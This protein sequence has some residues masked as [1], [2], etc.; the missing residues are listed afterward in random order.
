MTTLPQAVRRSD[1]L[2]KYV[3]LVFLI[4]LLGVMFFP[5]LIVL[6]N[7]F[8]TPAEYAGGGPL[9]LPRGL[10][11]AGITEFWS[12]V[13]F[14]NKLLNSALISLAVAVA[15]VLLSLLNAFALGIGKVRGR[16]GLLVFFLIANTLPQE[17]LA[18][19]LYYFAKALKIYDTQLAVIIVFSVIQSAFG[20]YLLSSVFSTFPKELIEAA[21]IDGCNK[22]QLLLWVVLPASVPTLAVLFT[23]FFIWTWNEFFLP[24]ILLIS[25]ARQTVPLAIAVLQGQH[26]MDATTSSASAL[27]G[28]LPCILFFL[29]FQRTLTRGV[30]AG[31]IK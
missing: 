17:S 22:L 2:G 20:T 31:S 5:F 7:A 21:Q 16:L 14:T 12:R 19:P 6:I 10:S 26:N 27:L 4:A 15:G 28:I 23:F 11:L 9:S 24:L 8:K 3:V 18:Y 1:G 29:V 13:N 30:M 25:N